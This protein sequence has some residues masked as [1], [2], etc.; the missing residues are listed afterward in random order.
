[1]L[2]I[3]LL[4]LLWGCS[5]H[6]SEQV[7]ANIARLKNLAVIPADAKPAYRIN[8]KKDGVYGSTKEVLI[9]QITG[10]AVDD[11]S[12]VFISDGQ[13]QIIHV[14]E[15]DGSYLT[16]I[17]RKGRGPG[18]FV[19]WAVPVISSNLLYAFDSMAMRINI[20]S[21]NSLTLV[22]TVNLKPTS[23]SG[24]RGLSRYLASRIFPRSDGTFLV[25]FLQPRIMNPRLPGFN[26]DS[27]YRKFYLMNDRGRII[28]KLIFQQKGNTYLGAT[29]DGQYRATT[30]PFLGR[31]LLAIGKDGSFYTART[32][33]FLIKMFR[34]DGKYLR[35][36]YYPY[37]KLKLTRQN[38]SKSFLSK[39]KQLVDYWESIVRRNTLPKTWPALYD[40]KIDNQNR[41]WVATIVNNFKV[42]QW[43]VL[44]RK[45]KLLARFNWPRSKP[46]KVVKNGYIYTQETDTATGISKIVRYRILMKPTG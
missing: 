24:I 45:G 40:M 1:M 8:F 17:G 14:F 43:W 16:H 30:F 18:E 38:V 22:Q 11:S 13:Q 46:I 2:L 33:D 29:V 20:F 32:T 31:P 6:K 3:V 5:A 10:I 7:P 44:N 26:L 21:L 12:R 23:R 15:P 41:L 35:A 27:L 19:G 36:L 25:G 28:S 37:P 34:R 4:I 39:E 9:G 42:C